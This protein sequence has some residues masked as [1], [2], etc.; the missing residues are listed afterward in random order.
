[1][2]DVGWSGR[3]ASSKG[4]YTVAFFLLFSFM[5]LMVHVTYKWSGKISFSYLALRIAFE[6]YL[7]NLT[8]GI[9]RC[10]DRRFWSF[11]N[12]S[13]AWNPCDV[14]NKSAGYRLAPLDPYTC[15]GFTDFRFQ[16]TCNITWRKPFVEAAHLTY[17][18]AR[19]DSAITF[20][21]EPLPG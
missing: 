1:M 5:N 4:I 2:P 21:A 3:M 10:R 6:G 11:H 7:T 20:M 17:K 8:N 13:A 12:C 18:A 16:G 14:R 15:F 9:P 19:Q